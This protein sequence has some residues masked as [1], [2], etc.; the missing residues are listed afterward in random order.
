M[1]TFLV[2]GA[3]RDQLMGRE[4]ADRDY[5][6]IGATVEQMLANGFI[7]V[8]ADFPVFLHP[9][10]NE[11]YALGRTERKSGTGYHGFLV[12][13]HNVTLPE[14]LSRRDL[15]INA[16]A[17]D[18]QGTLIDPFGGKADLDGCVLR[19]VSAA[20][21][22]DPVRILRVGR[23][24]ARYGAG[25]SVAEQTMALM[26]DMVAQGEAHHLTAERVWKELSR[27]LM[28]PYP[29]VM[30]RFYQQLGLFELP[31]FA[32]YPLRPHAA[33]PLQQA[34]LDA[35][36][37]E[38]RFGVAFA[39]HE[40][41]AKVP[42]MMVQVSQA[43][44]KLLAESSQERTAADAQSRLH[45][46]ERIDA[47]RQQ[48]RAHW[49]LQALAAFDVDFANAVRKDLELVNAVD[50]KAVARALPPGPQVGEAIREARLKAL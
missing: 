31:C 32:S 37:L 46:L 39:V 44:T 25:W 24:L 27:G 41:G 35:A 38:V 6:V 33:L 10:T 43:L 14:D 15:T 19:H 42:A 22:E 3:V 47:L 16:M 4:V 50:V 23:F 36:V 30:V 17:L 34:T 40:P 1:Q 20:F 8:G 2:G 11:E 45:R 49:T 29:L 21:R 48:S 18:E 28:E 26:Q 13:T 12:D 9:Q 5:V 7:Q